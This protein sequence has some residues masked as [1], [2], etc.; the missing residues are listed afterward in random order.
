MVFVEYA[1]KQDGV[2]YGY[3]SL[4]DLKPSDLRCRPRLRG[5]YLVSVASIPLT[6][7]TALPLPS[8]TPPPSCR[9]LPIHSVPSAHRRLHFVIIYH[10]GIL[11]P[12]AII[13]STAVVVSHP[14]SSLLRV[15]FLIET[16]RIDRLNLRRTE[17]RTPI[18]FHVTAC[19]HHL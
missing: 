19:D 5:I 4:H 7:F 11:Y 10:S 9:R 15:S 14:P 17:T 6:S 2:L 12:T 8:P 18:D 16:S 13:F 1:V 3:E